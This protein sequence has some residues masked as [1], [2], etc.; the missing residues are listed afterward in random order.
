LFQLTY[1]ELRRLAAARMS[2]EREDHTLTATALVHEAWLR[3]SGGDVPAFQSRSHFLAAV[4][5][6]MRRILIESYRRRSAQK[7][8]GGQVV[9]AR[10]A[11]VPW[12]DH[13]EEMLAVNEEL[14]HLEQSFPRQAH[15]FKLRCFGGVTMEEIAEVLQI[16]RR[17]AA[18]DWNFAKAWLGRKLGPQRTRASTTD[19]SRTIS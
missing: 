2:Q 13:H 17:T 3:I 4:S 7:R 18:N 19:S 16:S 8:G 6:A 9:R 14:E 5:E 10:N 12:C 15:V 11:E 1:H